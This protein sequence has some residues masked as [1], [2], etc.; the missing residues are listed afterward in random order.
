MKKLFKIT[1]ILA[2]LGIMLYQCQKSPKEEA[3]PTIS[4]HWVNLTDIHPDW[5]YEFTDNVLTQYIVDFGATI[6]WQQYP[7]A[8]RGDTVLIGGDTNDPN[9]IWKVTFWCDSIAEVH[10][11]TP[12]VMIAPV[13][14][15]RKLK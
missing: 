14:Y 7:Y 4:G 3:L 10:N 11:I 2:L 1:P 12:G 9:R 5:Q 13:L 8:V 15:L 6:A